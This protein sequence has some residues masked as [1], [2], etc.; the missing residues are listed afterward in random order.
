MT[1]T[2]AV[3]KSSDLV[4]SAPKR[5]N[6]KSGMPDLTP[7]QIRRQEK[8]ALV[9][10]EAKKAAK[11]YGN[12]GTSL[13]VNHSLV[14]AGT[15]YV[16]P[17]KGKPMQEAIKKAFFNPMVGIDDVLDTIE[18]DYGLSGASLGASEDRLPTGLLGLDV[19]L[20]GGLVP[21]W[22]TFFG[23]EQ[24]CKSTGSSWLMISALFSEVPVISMWDF[25]GCHTIRTVLRTNLGEIQFK[26]VLKH[27]EI[28][29]DGHPEKTFIDIEGKGLEVET[30]GQMVKVDK[31]YYS[32]V[33]PTSI[34]TTE[35]G[36]EF[37][38]YAHP[39][40][41]VTAGG[42]LVYRRLESIRSGE[43]VVVRKQ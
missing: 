42:D 13:K 11:K 33:R 12:G 20:G 3:V 28:P 43:Q 35:S 21:G 7:A 14:A 16:S 5:Q 30:L 9:A 31:L 19:V 17:P 22:Y 38:G 10:E 27:L 34:L 40:L 32:G 6:S 18:K 8:Q 39:M 41:C 37:E 4:E 15:G 29:E 24:S 1:R 25:E 26:N 2:K 36:M 23:G